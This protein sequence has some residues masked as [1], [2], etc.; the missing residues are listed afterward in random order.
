MNSLSSSASEPFIPKHDKDGYSEARSSDDE[1]ADIFIPRTRPRGRL[2]TILSWIS[3]VVIIAL[4]LYSVIT[5][6]ISAADRIHKAALPP[7]YCGPTVTDA[8]SKGCKFD[9]LATSWLPAHCRDDQLTALFEK[10]G[11]GPNGEWMY[12]ES[13]SSSSRLFTIDEMALM[14][15]R[16]DPK[17]RDVWVTV[18]WHN[19]HCFYTLVKQARGK[20]KMEY[21]GFPSAQAH[22]EHC[23][24]VMTERKAGKRILVQI[25]PGLGDPRPGET[26][27]VE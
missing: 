18:D 2:V 13:N 23:A 8:I 16:A 25:E 7:C 20:T 24:V 21:T 27:I 5:L 17:E 15:D 19:S 3:K 9:S 22:A 14:A 26:W 10:A 12:H 11:P 6:G 1:D 4:A